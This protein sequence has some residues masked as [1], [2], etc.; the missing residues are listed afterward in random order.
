[1]NI[2]KKE[3]R[4]QFVKDV[5]FYNLTDLLKLVNE[6]TGK[7]TTVSELLRLAP[8][9]NALKKSQSFHEIALIKKVGRGGSSYASPLFFL[10]VACFLMGEHVLSNQW[11]VNLYD[12]AKIQNR[13][14]LEDI[15]NTIKSRLNKAASKQAIKE[16]EENIS[17]IEGLNLQQ[18]NQFTKDISDALVLVDDV[19]TAFQIVLNQLK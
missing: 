15:K 9:K 7:K 16:I 5:E 11:I 4:L 6:K 12:V 8:V 10:N 18:Y 1:M 17:L 3:I 19:K 14:Y 2:S 13:S